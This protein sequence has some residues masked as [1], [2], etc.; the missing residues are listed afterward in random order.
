MVLHHKN[1]HPYLPLDSVLYGDY[2]EIQEKDPIRDM[3]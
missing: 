2:V 3:T 1:F